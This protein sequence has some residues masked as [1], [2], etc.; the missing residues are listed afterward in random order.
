MLMIKKPRLFLYMTFVVVFCSIGSFAWADR[1]I[2]EIADTY[3]Y[4]VRLVSQKEAQTI[5]SRQISAYEQTMSMKEKAILKDLRE[6]D[7]KTIPLTIQYL[8]SEAQKNHKMGNFQET[9]LYT[10]LVTAIDPKFS[11]AHELKVI[12]LKILKSYDEGI[13]EYT[14]FATK[15]SESIDFVEYIETL[16]TAREENELVSMGIREAVNRGIQLYKKDKN[17]GK[18]YFDGVLNVY[19]KV[20]RYDDEIYAINAFKKIYEEDTNWIET[21][22][23]CNRYLQLKYDDITVKGWNAIR[24]DYT[25]IFKSVYKYFDNLNDFKGYVNWLNEYTKIENKR[26]MEESGD[27]IQFYK[28]KALMKARDYENAQS[29]FLNLYLNHPTSPLSK[30]AKVYYDR[31]RQAIKGMAVIS[32]TTDPPQAEVYIDGLVRGKTPL[33][34]EVPDRDQKIKIVKNAYDAYE[35]TIVPNIAEGELVLNIQLSSSILTFR[36][37]SR[38][39]CPGIVLNLIDLG[40]IKW[41]QDCFDLQTLEINGPFE[42]LDNNSVRLPSG[43]YTIKMCSFGE[44]YKQTGKYIHSHMHVPTGKKV[45]VTVDGAY[46]DDPKYPFLVDIT[47]Q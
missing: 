9:I 1:L 10:R 37:K 34:I 47:G 29:V 27:L 24:K 23:L 26:F 11:R 7:F 21:I 14:A 16:K 43:D 12:S 31:I 22:K 18:E 19:H 44:L 25:D 36:A 46:I 33:K 28:G 17:Q 41:H 5:G 13:S 40:E 45:T 39:Y 42:K 35:E 15:F 30:E 32:I 3:T 4:T 6:K 38:N 20:S 8:F 2:I